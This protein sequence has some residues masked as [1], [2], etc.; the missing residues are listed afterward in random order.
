M[1]GADNSLMDMNSEP[2]SVVIDDN[3]TTAL[4]DRHDRSVQLKQSAKYGNHQQFNALV[5]LSKGY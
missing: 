3:V 4:M 1:I 5:T 2:K